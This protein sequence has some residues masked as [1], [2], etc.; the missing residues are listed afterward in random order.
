MAE[1]DQYVKFANDFEGTF[2]IGGN[3]A[4]LCDESIRTRVKQ[5]Y[6]DYSLLISIANGGSKITIPALTTPGQKDIETT[7]TNKIAM[8]RAYT[9]A[10]FAYQYV[11]KAL[12]R[13]I[14]TDYRPTEQSIIKVSDEDGTMN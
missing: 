5:F 4:L 2:Q 14:H 12:D 6:S 7:N 3:G 11:C 1:Y 8:Q 10:F 9:F 13:E